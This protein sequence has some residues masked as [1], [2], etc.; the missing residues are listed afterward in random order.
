MK[1]IKK[2]NE[3]DGEFKIRFDKTKPIYQSIDIVKNHIELV[4]EENDD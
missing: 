3:N 4:K 1:K 2:K